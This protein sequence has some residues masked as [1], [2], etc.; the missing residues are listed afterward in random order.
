MGAGGGGEGRGD[1]KGLSVEVLS[2]VGVFASCQ[3]CSI[4]NCPSVHVA[5]RLS[6]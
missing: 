4:N 3:E 6:M 5:V 1:Y 2:L